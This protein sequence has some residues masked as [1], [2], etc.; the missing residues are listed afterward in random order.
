MLGSFAD[1]EQNI[2]HLELHPGMSVADFG[3]GAGAYSFAS[4][5]RVGGTGHVYAVEVQKDL[6]EKLKREAKEKHIGT[7]EVVWGDLDVG[8]GSKLKD[9]SMDAVVISNVLFQSENRGAMIRE[10]HRVLKPAGKVLYIEWSDSFK[11]LGPTQAQVIS[12]PSARK[13]FEEAGFRVMPPFHAGAHH[14][15]F[16]AKKT[17]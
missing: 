8:G 11:N 14:Y 7:I 12:E 2:G 5:R 6:L 10:A 17:E 13:M 4:A 1:P 9:S 3:A 16:I 15:G